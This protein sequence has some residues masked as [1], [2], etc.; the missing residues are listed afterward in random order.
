M[1]AFSFFSNFHRS[2]ATFSFITNYKG[3]TYLCQLEAENLDIAVR[4]WKDFINTER[5]IPGMDYE[6]FSETFDWHIEEFPPSPFEA[7]AN[8]WGIDFTVKKSLLELYIIQTDTSHANVEV[9]T[10]KVIP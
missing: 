7:M 3:G 10:L 8:S 4:K 2:M 5:F 9:K 6:D 1:D